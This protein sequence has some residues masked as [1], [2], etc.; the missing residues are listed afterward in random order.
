MHLKTIDPT[1][2]P[3]WLQ[4]VTDSPSTLF[5]SPEWCQVLTDTYGFAPEATVLV[6]EH[7]VPRAGFLYVNIDDAMDPRIVS[8]PFSDFCDPIVRDMA[9]WEALIGDLV[10]SDHRIQLRC[11]HGDVPLGDA[12]FETVGRA[13]WHA[14]DLDRDLDDIWNGLDSSARQS[15]RKAR[16]QGVEIRVAESKSD[17]RAFFE[18]HLGVRKR[19]YE[20]LAQP[21]RFFEQIWERLLSR[22]RG[23]LLLGLHQGRVV[24]GIMFLEWQQTLFYKFNASDD[25]QLSVR[26]NDVLIWAG[27]EHAKAR[28]LR[29]FDFGLSDW[30]QEGLLRYKRKYATVE[31]PI[32]F[33][34]RM[35]EGAPSSR[36]R[37]LRA[38]LP[39]LTAI[40]VDPNVPDATSEAAGDLLYRFFV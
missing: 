3:L 38:M 34:R 1:T 12:R 2:D 13:R 8:L 24:S 21:Y 19:K 31:K 9:D 6:D 14:I 37:Q 27:I 36:E 11:L 28:D 33:L 29:R 35:P 17:L 15:I 4:L 39:Q 30:D 40:L 23:A 22:D 18:L 10:N 32:Y 20:L 5:H 16:N 25:S 26:P 7:D